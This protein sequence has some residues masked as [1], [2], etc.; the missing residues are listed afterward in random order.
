MSFP[1]QLNSLKPNLSLCMQG[2]IKQEEFNKIAKQMR[3]LARSTPQDK[4]TLVRGLKDA[5]SST[6]EG[7]NVVAVTGDGT[8]D[9]PALKRADVGFAMGKSG[10]SVAKD[11]ADILLLDDTFNS[12]VSAVRWGRHVYTSVGMFLQMQLTVNC[13]AVA[14]AC[15]GTVV[16]QESPLTAVQMLWVNL[17]MDT[18]A[19][20]AFASEEPT[21]ASLSQKPFSTA[22]SPVTGT[23]LK[24]IVSQSVLQLVILFGLLW[25]GDA[26]FSVES[27]RGMLMAGEGASEHY[28]IIFNSFVL[29]QIFNQINSRKIADETNVLDGLLENK[30]FIAITC[31]EF[32]TQVTIVQF[33]D[34]AVQ[35]VP[36]SIQ[37]WAACAGFGALSLLLRRA[38]LTIKL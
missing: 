12:I 13:S 3:V 2:N 15:V 26:L 8:N 35:T 25:E 38:L 4:Y 31:L 24:N 10:T 6:G 28:T 37:E 11:A 9:A 30:S 20:L 21:K 19:G 32:V 14:L 27:G 1:C 36:L 5:P 17:I 18:L 16:N 23:M 33:G 29:M 34:G 22:A 7:E